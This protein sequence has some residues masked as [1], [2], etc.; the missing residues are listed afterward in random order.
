MFFTSKIFC[1][2]G[3]ILELFILSSDCSSH[4]SLQSAPSLST[5]RR[6]KMSVFSHLVLSHHRAGTYHSRVLLMQSETLSEGRARA[7][8][9]MRGDV[10]GG[11]PSLLVSPRGDAAALPLSPSCDC[12]SGLLHLFLWRRERG[13]G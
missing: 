9:C 12:N 10:C 11:L 1:G 13:G 6:R 3:G 8:V 4:L 5:F 7:C 2:G